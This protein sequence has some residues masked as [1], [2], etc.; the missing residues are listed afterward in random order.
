MSSGSLNYWDFVF[1]V[2]S[3]QKKHSHT[4][5]PI[6]LSI[7]PTKKQPRERERKQQQVEIHERKK[8]RI[9]ERNS[10]TP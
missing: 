5:S 2:A 6:I 4:F 8:R 9:Q 1:V 3:R 7:Q 10:K